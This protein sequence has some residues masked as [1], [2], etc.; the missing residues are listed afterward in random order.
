[1]VWKRL[2]ASCCRR[3]VRKRI[4]PQSLPFRQLM[5]KLNRFQGRDGPS[6]GTAAGCTGKLDRL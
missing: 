4:G 1:M 3:G 2:L 6:P 5:G